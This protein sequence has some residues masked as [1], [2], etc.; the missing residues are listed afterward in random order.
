MAPV[1]DRQRDDPESNMG[2]RPAKMKPVTGDRSGSGGKAGG[3]KGLTF[4]SVLALSCPRLPVRN[5]FSGH[6]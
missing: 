4:A 6:A 1:W 2:Y 5:L 3:R